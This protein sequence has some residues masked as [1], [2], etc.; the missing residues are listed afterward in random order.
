MRKAL[1]SELWLERT[2]FK[3]DIVLGQI[4][5][6]KLVSY[7]PPVWCFLSNSIDGFS[8]EDINLNWNIFVIL[9]NSVG[10]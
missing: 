9:C 1:N 4:S 8:L 6:S 7:P 3:I 10:S 5:L 2:H